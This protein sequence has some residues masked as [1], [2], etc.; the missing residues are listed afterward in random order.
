ML[1]HSK[2]LVFLLTA[3]GIFS[4]QSPLHADEYLSLNFGTS[5]RSGLGMSYNLG[6][7]SFSAG[8]MGLGFSDSRDLA[9][10]PGL[11]YTRFFTDN[12]WYGTFGY[13]RAFKNNEDVSIST[14]SPGLD[15]WEGQNGTGWA[16]GEILIG[17]GKNFQWSSWGLNVDAGLA[18][19]GGSE[20]AKPLGYRAGLG[21]SYRFK[22]K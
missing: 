8:L 3:L 9:I 14:S 13:S 17:A 15:D 10:Q 2:T 16:S 12:G 7:N 5:S 21:G 18:L 19:S 22:L 20:F 1:I 4:A 11:S 6:R